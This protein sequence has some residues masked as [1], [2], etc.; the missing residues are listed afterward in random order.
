M[1]PDFVSD[2]TCLSDVSGL[3]VRRDRTVCPRCSDC[4]SEVSGLCVCLM[5]L[6]CVP[7][8]FAARDRTVCPM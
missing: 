5:R 4:V 2:M 7:D 3:C 8:L 1:R 6:I